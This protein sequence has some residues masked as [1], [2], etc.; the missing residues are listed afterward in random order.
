[1]TRVLVCPFMAWADGVD[2]MTKSSQ[3]AAKMK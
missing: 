2:Q 1:M 3:F